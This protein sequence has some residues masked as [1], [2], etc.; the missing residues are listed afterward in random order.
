MSSSGTTSVIHSTTASTANL[1]SW[2]TEE[3]WID[4]QEKFLLDPKASQQSPTKRRRRNSTRRTGRF[5]SEDKDAGHFEHSSLSTA[6]IHISHDFS[7]DHGME[8][9]FDGFPILPQ[10]EQVF[11]CHKA[12]NRFYGDFNLLA[13]ANLNWDCSLSMAGPVDDL[14]SVL[15]V[16][17]QEQT[18]ET[19]IN[20]LSH[21]FSIE[22]LCRTPSPELQSIARYEMSASI[23]YFNHGKTQVSRMLQNEITCPELI[24]ESQDWWASCKIAE[25]GRMQ[26]SYANLEH[27]EQLNVDRLF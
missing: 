17:E 14:V 11:T 24:E 5:R 10:N 7:L 27:F 23:D 3:A 9:T 6:S 4:R 2:S 1:R 18:V 13:A 21:D 16:H 8:E 19:I 22:L 26:S 25:I 12:I 15:A 20:P